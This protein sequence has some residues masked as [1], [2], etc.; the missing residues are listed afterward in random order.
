MFDATPRFISLQAPPRHSSD[1]SLNAASGG[2]PGD[3]ACH[4]LSHG[5]SPAPQDWISPT[6]RFVERTVEAESEADRAPHPL[7][8]LRA[9]TQNFDD[10]FHTACGCIPLE[11][12]ETFRGLASGDT[13]A[14]FLKRAL[15]D[16]T[17]PVLRML[18]LEPPSQYFR[19]GRAVA[20]DCSL[21][22]DLRH[23]SDVHRGASLVLAESS[24]LRDFAA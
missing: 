10:H 23:G 22:F 6:A 13:F 19:A 2:S 3:I 18:P 5:R 11:L 20:F 9:P 24:L 21:E 16:R 14:H 1:T 15:G 8:F 17:H 12:E 7:Q 4:R